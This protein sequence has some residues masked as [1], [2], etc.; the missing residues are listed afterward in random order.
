MA[1]KFPPL[2]INRFAY[3]TRIECVQLVA[4]DV[5]SSFAFQELYVCLGAADS[6]NAS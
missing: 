3:Q 2:L 6:S 1:V 5:L 4:L